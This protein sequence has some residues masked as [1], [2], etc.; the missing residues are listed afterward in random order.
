METFVTAAVL[1]SYLLF[2][3]LDFWRPARAFPRIPFWRA[4]GVIFF[5][6]NLSL[7]M[8]LPLLWDG[9][10]GRFR[11]LDATGLGTVGGA[12]FGLIVL[13]LGVYVWHRALHGVPFLWRTFHQMHHSAERLDVFGAL[14]S[15]PLDAA[16]FALLYSLALV[17]LTG[18]SA[19]AAMLASGAASFLSFFQHANVKTP[20]WLGYVIQRPEM[21]AVHH[22]RG[23]HHHN[24]SDFPVFDLL[25][26]TF[27]NPPDWRGQAGFYDG[28]SKRIGEMLIGRDVAA[29]P[30]RQS[31][32]LRP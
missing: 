26:G 1:G 4:K 20:R 5:L 12:V 21:H 28:G 2:I 10:L 14:Y 27:R 19:E 7:S 3:A 30:Q 22:E 29:P 31:L 8:T 32:E 23:V 17:V 24:F 25:F 9:W 18:V 6:L 15:H 16:G 13:Q 11:L